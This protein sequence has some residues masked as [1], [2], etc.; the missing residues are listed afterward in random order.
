MNYL[1]PPKQ[2]LPSGHESEDK[3]DVHEGFTGIPRIKIDPEVRE[4]SRW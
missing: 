2:W 3:N 1:E 4:T